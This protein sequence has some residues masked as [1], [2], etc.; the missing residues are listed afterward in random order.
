MSKLTNFIKKIFTKDT[1]IGG[2]VVIG[3]MMA[4]QP[5]NMAVE[6][7][8]T[9]NLSVKVATLNSDKWTY[10]QSED[11]IKKYADKN[12]MVYSDAKRELLFNKDFV[13]QA[14]PRFIETAIRVERKKAANRGETFEYC[15]D[16]VKPI[17]IENGSKAENKECIRVRPKNN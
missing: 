10:E 13:N 6:K 14:D 8:A 4:L 15:L 12:R 5:D 17:I 11:F 7:D 9:N 1:V 3:A 16:Q 2:T